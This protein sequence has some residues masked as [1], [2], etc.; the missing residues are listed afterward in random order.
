MSLLFYH[1]PPQVVAFFLK[2]VIRSSSTNV[3]PSACL[4]GAIRLLFESSLFHHWQPQAIGFFLS[5]II[6][7]IWRYYSDVTYSYSLLQEAVVVRRVLLNLPMVL[8]SLHQVSTLLLLCIICRGF[9]GCTLC[10]VNNLWDIQQVYFCILCISGWLC[11]FVLFQYWPSLFCSSYHAGICLPSFN[12]WLNSVFCVVVLCVVYFSVLMAYNKLDL[13]SS[14]G[15]GRADNVPVQVT[16][17]WLTK[18]NYLQ[19]SA[20]ITIGIAGRGRFAYIAG[21]KPPPPENDPQWET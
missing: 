17:I 4:H 1:W 18:D 15:S 5:W 6:L 7:G 3:I 13:Y 11:S 8:S 21:H 16:T 14:E 12:F 19:W 2:T 20:T 9:N 10:C